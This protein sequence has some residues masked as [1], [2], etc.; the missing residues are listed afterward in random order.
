MAT[1]IIPSNVSGSVTVGSFELASNDGNVVLQEITLLNLDDT[2]VSSTVDA[3]TSSGHIN[4]T[5]DG[6]VVQL[7]Q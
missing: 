4:T 7:Y 3:T 1:S 5:S 2:F 6:A